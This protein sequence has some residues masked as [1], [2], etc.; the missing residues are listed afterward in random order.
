MYLIVI[1]EEIFHFFII[2]VFIVPCL[3]KHLGTGYLFRNTLV[4]DIS[5]NDVQVMS[6]NFNYLI[7]P[8]I[9]YTQVLVWISESHFVLLHS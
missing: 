6:R 5:G 3:H 9:Y 1:V 4:I 7:S 8:G 2:F